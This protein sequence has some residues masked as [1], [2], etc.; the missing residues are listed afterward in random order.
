MTNATHFGGFY[1]KKL[2][3]S[4]PNLRWGCIFPSHQNAGEIGENGGKIGCGFASKIYNPTHL[5]KSDIENQF[6]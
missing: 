3:K 1:G 6:G 5:R 4:L 2:F